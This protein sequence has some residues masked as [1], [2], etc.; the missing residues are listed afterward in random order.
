[1]Q[2]LCSIFVMC[3]ILVQAYRLPMYVIMEFLWTIPTYRV[4]I[5]QL[6]DE[7]ILHPFVVVLKLSTATA[8]GSHVCPDKIMNVMDSL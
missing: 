2:W 6:S 8:V 7:V 4:S 3:N 5:E 1:M